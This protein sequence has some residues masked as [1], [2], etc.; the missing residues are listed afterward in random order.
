MVSSICMCLLIY[1]CVSIYVQL[2]VHVHFH[3]WQSYKS[4]RPTKNYSIS[5][6][7]SFKMAQPNFH[8]HYSL[9]KYKTEQHVLSNQSPRVAYIKTNSTISYKK[10]QLI[11]MISGLD[12]LYCMGFLPSPTTAFFA[13]YNHIRAAE[14]TAQPH[15][16]THTHNYKTHQTK[17]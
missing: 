8:H 6:E 10:N 13:T 17:T 15:I 9:Y 2:S 5:I 4:K 1:V 14:S 16:P 7:G 12:G 3:H 11:Q